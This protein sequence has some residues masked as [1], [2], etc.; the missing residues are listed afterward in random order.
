MGN[1]TEIQLI[2]F[3]MFSEF[4]CGYQCEHS[5]TLFRVLLSSDKFWLAMN[6]LKMEN[7]VTL[8]KA[9]I[10]P[11]GDENHLSCEFHRMPCSFSLVIFWGL[12]RLLGL[13][14]LKFMGKDCI[15]YL[16]HPV[17]HPKVPLLSQKPSDRMD[18]LFIKSSLHIYLADIYK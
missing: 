12:Q 16:R 8:T 3:R 11:D 14:Q 15:R 2:N 9:K 7:V 6:D 13:C 17:L 10:R 1:S 5:Y 18:D 4:N